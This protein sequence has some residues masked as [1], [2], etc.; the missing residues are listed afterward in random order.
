LCTQIF[1]IFCSVTVSFAS[2][3]SAWIRQSRP[4]TAPNLAIPGFARLNESLQK[5]GSVKVIVRFVPPASLTNGFVIEGHLPNQ[6]AVAVQ[7]AH[8]AQIQTRISNLLS[9]QRSATAK[10]FDFIHFMAM[11]V[12]AAEFQMLAASQDIDLIEEDIPVPPTLFQS[13]P[14]IG[15]ISG[16]FNGFTGNG[17]TVAILDTGVDKTHP[18]LTGKVVTEACYSTTYAADSATPACTSGSTSAGS[19]APCA[20]SGCEHGTHVAGIAAGNGTSNGTHFSGVAKDANIIAIQI[21]TRVGDATVCGGTAP[22][23]LSYTSDQISALNRVY[24]LRGTYNIAAVNMSLGGGGS[25]SYCDASNVSEKAAIDALRSVGIATV[26]ASGNDGNSN[27]VSAPACISTAISVGA[28][29]KSD[30]VATYSNSASILNLLAPGSSIYSS[31]PG[32]G[33]AY[34]SGTSMATPHVTGAWAVLK[35]AKPS[36]TVTEVLSA[37]TSTG[38]SITDSRNSIVKPRIQLDAAINAL[39]PPSANYTLTVSKIGSGGGTITSNPVYGISCGTTCSSIIPVPQGNTLSLT[40]VPNVGS[41]FV[42][43]SGGACSGNFNPCIISSA[44]ENMSVIANFLSGTTI[45][46]VPFSGA[47]VPTGW[48]AQADLGGLNRTWSIVTTSGTNITGGTG[49]YASLYAAGN[50]L[51]VDSSLVSSSYNLSLYTG[52]ALS[53]KTYFNYWNDS[54]GD[55]DVSSDGGANWTNVWR[56]GPGT[57]DSHYGPV[58]ESVDISSLA[59][60]KSNVKIRF[61]YYTDDYGY[62]WDVDDFA[63]YGVSS[64]SAPTITSVKAGNT[65]ASIY[66]SSPASDGGTSITGYTVTSSVGTTSPSLVIPITVSGLSDAASY[67]FTVTAINLVG[68]GTPSTPFINVTPGLVINSGFDATGY[69]TIQ[70]AYAGPHNITIQ[71]LSG[72]NV[73]ALVKS[74]SDS[75]VIIGGF[76]SGFLSNVG[77]PSRLSNITL[78]GGT[79]RVQNV[80]VRSN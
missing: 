51:N 19:G 15:G 17:Q 29:D 14:L 33:F 22:C 40:A 41:V 52:V 73:G 39:K 58:T 63:L 6:A 38:K 32:G 74:D 68:P 69:Q 50:Y 26:I 5:N 55:V 4:A 46:A 28:T 25:S 37:L 13:A 31:V 3:L 42:G 53:F 72:V 27:L 20:I 1:F 23:V 12:S 11:E 65:Q 75:I 57:N 21:F 80:V 47:A 49:N 67:S 44:S 43:W 7:R 34:L 64:P 60:G 48:T 79:T 70:A 30:V 2:D 9:K 24:S 77:A 54:V 78:T 71:I 35:S 56:R 66:F 18:F 76:D 45:I 16:I 62:Y 59:A 10:R 36:A 8:I 61:R